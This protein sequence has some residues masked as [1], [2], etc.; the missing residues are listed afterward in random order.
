MLLSWPEPS[1]KKVWGLNAILFFP[2]LKDPR[3]AVWLC[4]LIFFVIGVQ[5]GFFSK[6]YDALLVC[7]LVAGVLD[8]LIM[9][10]KLKK[11]IFPQS[12]FIAGT[13]IALL[14][15][16][17]D[18]SFYAMG[19]AA[20]ILSKHAF[21]AIG[22]HIYNPSAYGALITMLLFPTQAINN[23]SQWGGATWFTALIFTTGIIVTSFAHVLDIA[24][25]WILSFTAFAFF[26]AGFLHL[27]LITTVGVMSGASFALFSFFMITDPKTVPII[28]WQR[29]IFCFLAAG[30]DTIFRLNKNP[31]APF[32][33]I[34]A[35]ASLY[36]VG[37][38]LFT[39]IAG[40]N[41]TIR[42]T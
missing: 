16:C 11:N 10:K 5:C 38:F 24:F 36:T 22:R 41:K 32:W 9:R 27:P 14:I 42:V 26:R 7:I 25:F 37:E 2:S 17:P 3:P 28:W 18:L 20:A 31:Y 23:G 13:G 12:G 33:G 21:K 29:F 1:P 39:R 4:Q 15:E 30:I 40:G 8:F 35:A 34:V 19:A 6:N